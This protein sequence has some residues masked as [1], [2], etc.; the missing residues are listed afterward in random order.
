MRRRPWLL[1]ALVELGSA[2]EHAVDELGGEAAIAIV[3]LRAEDPPQR[4]PGEG[5]L[6]EHAA[7]GLQGS[8]TR[9]VSHRR[10][11]RG[12]PDR[13]KRCARLRGLL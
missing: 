6:G 7:Q 1:S 9:Q 10:K 8:V 4:G 11:L 2:A 12:A 3:E 5:A 13:D